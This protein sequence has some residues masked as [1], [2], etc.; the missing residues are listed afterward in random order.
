MQV[1]KQIVVLNKLGLHARAATKLVK[2]CNRFESQIILAKG[3][4]EV[5]AKSIMGILMLAATQGTH[6]TIKAQGDDANNAVAQ[7]SGLFERLFDEGE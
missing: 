3:E 4:Q 6:L 5:N 1:E 7:I 2:L